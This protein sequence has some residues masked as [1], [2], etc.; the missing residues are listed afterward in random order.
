MPLGWSDGSTHARSPGYL[1]HQCEHGLAWSC[2]KWG[3]SLN[4]HISE[5]PVT[6]LLLGHKV[7]EFVD[8][9]TM[10]LITKTAYQHVQCILAI[11]D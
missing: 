5:L 4:G 8:K 11:G 2:L 3:A 1:Q 7:P 10:I 9:A 6:Q